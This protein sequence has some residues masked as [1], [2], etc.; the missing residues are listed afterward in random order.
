MGIALS[1]H[2]V[3]PWTGSQSGDMPAGACP[4]VGTCMPRG[5]SA[6]TRCA[7]CKEMDDPAV[8]RGQKQDGRCEPEEA[9]LSLVSCFPW[10]PQ[11]PLVTGVV[12][13]G[14]ALKAV[15][16]PSPPAPPAAPTSIQLEV[17]VLH[18]CCPRGTQPARA[19][20]GGSNGCTCA[21]PP[22]PPHVP[23]VLA[24]PA[25]AVATPA[26]TAV[27]LRPSLERGSASMERL[28]GSPAQIQ[29]LDLVPCWD[30]CEA[31]PLQ[32]DLVEQGCDPPQFL[33]ILAFE[34]MQIY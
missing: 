28:P 5:I 7:G 3:S 30:P 6:P 26:A 21:A 17:S 12:V 24:G 8:Q 33:L 29:G 1:C 2:S 25:A 20:L 10:S 22:T 16:V 18:L 31:V 13:R 14:F 15:P 23:Q 32:G 4:G 11:R 27:P 9:R 19:K 34:G